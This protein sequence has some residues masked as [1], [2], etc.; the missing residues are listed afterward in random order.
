MG[1]AKNCPLDWHPGG[2]FPTPV[3]ASLLAMA[4]NDN[5]YFLN[6]RV[7][8]KSIASE[9]APTEKNISPALHPV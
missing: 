6:Q 9:L 4:V 3:G 5:A 7:A 2:L 8:L 1:G